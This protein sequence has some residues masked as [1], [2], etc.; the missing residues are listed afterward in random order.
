MKYY[1]VSEKD[2]QY[3]IECRAKLEALEAGGVDNWSWYGE[4]FENYLEDMKDEYDMEINEDLDFL[5]IVHREI[6]KFKEI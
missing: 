1:K 4:S 3:F 2:L 5:D 6:K